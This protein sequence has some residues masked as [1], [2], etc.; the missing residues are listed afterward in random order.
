MFRILTITLTLAMMSNAVA[1]V[2]KLD[3][4]VAVVDQKVITEQ[5]L[6]YHI[7]TVSARLKKQAIP[8]PD[9]DALRRQVLERLI[10][11]SLQLQYAA[12][13]GLKIDDAQLNQT[14]DRIA[15]QNKLTVPDFYRE[16]AKEG[17]NPQRFR[18]DIRNEITISRLREREIDSRLVI[19]EA[20][21]DSTL[22]LRGDG[23]EQKSYELAQ[24]FVRVPAEGNADEVQR[25]KEKL[26][27]V[28]ANLKLGIDFAQVSARFSDSSNALE[29]GTLGWRNASELP[30]LFGEALLN[31][32]VGELSQPLRSPSGVHI[33]KLINQRD[34]KVPLLVEQT[35]V[36]HILV[37][38]SEL[39]NEQESKQKIDGLRERL[40]NG[41]SFAKLARQYSDDTSASKGGDLGWVNPNDTVQP[42][43]NA[44]NALKIGELSPPVRS[45][46]GWHLISVLERRSQDMTKEATR[47]RVR[48]DIR[49]RK[50]DEA[51]QNWLR[52]LR[53]RAYVEL[54]WDDNL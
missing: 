46:F 11:D 32:R 20:E 36:Q 8:L 2:I 35:H 15:T 41:E 22:T 40:V 12:E 10:I 16:L 24:I 42:F 39:M 1:E 50:S 45:P 34:S 18:S 31:M 33:L 26:D 43:E 7:A 47:L 51:Y 29:G 49:A 30:P 53:D 37:R 38:T 3:R 23:Q 52:E 21:I 9:A 5:D 14:I 28:L 6:L 25:A 54:H 48:K 13:T 44:M 17:I 4:I 27:N 19:S